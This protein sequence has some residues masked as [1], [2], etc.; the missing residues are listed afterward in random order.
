MYAINVI[1]TYFPHRIVTKL[2]LT[3][4]FVGANPKAVDLLEKVLVLDTDVR[5]TAD[6]ALKHPYLEKFHDPE[7]EPSAPLYDKSYEDSE[8]TI[9]QWKK[10]A[11]DEIC[12]FT[13]SPDL[14]IDY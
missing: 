2:F 6:M 7:D 3:D 1:K 14:I 10:L 9:E 11:F 12:N 5:L 4:V 8:L 13:F